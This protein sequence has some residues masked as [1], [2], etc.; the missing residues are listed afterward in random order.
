MLPDAR[1]EILNPSEYLTIS[2]MITIPLEEQTWL[3][4]ARQGE[5]WALE[6]LYNAYHRPLYALCHR[7]LCRHEDAEDAMQTTFVKAFR[8][9]PKFRGKSAVKTWLYRIAVNEAITL[10]RQ[11]RITPLAM[12]ES[13]P[14]ADPTRSIAGRLAV[15]ATL[16]TM[17]PEQRALL[18]LLY[19]EEM[20]YE[21]IAAVLNISLSAVKMRL[22]R[23]RDEFQKRY[24]GEP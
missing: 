10:Q 8:A 17:K 23:A 20:S 19:W 3:E 15:Q 7:L 14:T 18:A 24:G 5:E 16:A 22:K 1:T 9:L 4:A 11:R 2:S 21:E 13:V 6:A 12:P